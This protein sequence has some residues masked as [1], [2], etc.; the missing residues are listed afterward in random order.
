MG[1]S[2]QSFFPMI[3][4]ICFQVSL[5]EDGSPFAPLI[6]LC[7][8]FDQAKSLVQFC[9]SLA[10]ASQ[11]QN[12]G[13]N[14]NTQ[15]TT[16]LATANSLLSSIGA[17]AKETSSS[18]AFVVVTSGRGRGKSAALGL[19]LAAAF[20]T[21]LPNLYVTAPS[22]ENLNTLMQFVVNGLN[23][24]QY[25][26]HQDYIVSRSMN[27]EHNQAT[28]RIDVYRRSHRQSLIYLPPWEMA[29]LSSV[30]Q[31]DL[32]CIDEAAAIPLPLVQSIISGPRIVFM[33]STINGYEGTGRSLSFKLLRQLRSQCTISGTTS[34]LSTDDVKSKSVQS[35][36][37]DKML[38]G[39]GFR[40]GKIFKVLL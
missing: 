7:I 38:L 3:S 17:G 19:G 30:K 12:K 37:K 33:A 5:A 15:D 9:A 14:K 40:S 24:F 21:G 1:A 20:E 10:S 31:A 29:A 35:T 6:K 32:V 39:K 26:E 25:E 18:S 27:P 28:V 23:A 4:V 16:S 13:C 34:K 2:F 36:G 22:P 11:L 8:T